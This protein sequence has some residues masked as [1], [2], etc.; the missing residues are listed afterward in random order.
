MLTPEEIMIRDLLRQEY[1]KAY[2]H[3]I[4]KDNSMEY[5]YTDDDKKTAIKTTLTLICFVVLL[6]CVRFFQ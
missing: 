3:K 4:E 5:K 1:P 6:F 2:H